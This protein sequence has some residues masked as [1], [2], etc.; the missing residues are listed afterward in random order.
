MLLYFQCWNMTRHHKCW[1]FVLARS[2]DEGFYLY[3]LQPTWRSINSIDGQKSVDFF[4]NKGKR[5]EK[6]NLCL[7]LGHFDARTMAVFGGR[8]RTNTWA[9]QRHLATLPTPL[10]IKFMLTEVLPSRKTQK[11]AHWSCVVLGWGGVG[12]HSF[13][14]DHPSHSLARFW[15]GTQEQFGVG[16]PILRIKTDV[17]QAGEIALNCE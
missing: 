14:W 10:P 15:W 1:D 8:S 5:K 13:A 17:S 2:L 7:S 12:W 11:I 3:H 6:N 9:L 4:H 16:G